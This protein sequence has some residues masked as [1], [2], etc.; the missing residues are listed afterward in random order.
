MNSK[1]KCSDL[2]DFSAQ[3]LR[4]EEV[5]DFC[6]QFEGRTLLVVN[7]ASRCGFTPQFK[8][9]EELNKRYADQGLSIVG[10]PSDDFRQEYDDAEE[11]AKVCYVNYG[12]TFDMV[13][14]SSVRGKNANDL[15]KKLAKI[16]GKEPSWN[17]NKYLVSA[18][19]EVRHFG[20]MKK[21]TNG[22]LEQAII[23]AL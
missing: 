17:F 19:G 8:G 6:E 12:V 1:Q 15:F 3:M 7:T 16:T 13:E 9:L 2:L 22:A 10:F 5:L 20:S 21:P 23:E 18:D 11:T 4:S 14:K